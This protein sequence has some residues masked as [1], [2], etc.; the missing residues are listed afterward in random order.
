MEKRILIVDDDA[1]ILDVLNEALCGDG[2]SVKMAEGG[3]DVFKLIDEYQPDLVIIDYILNGINGGE[4]CH[5]IKTN[6]KTSYLPVIILSAHP[7]V[8][9]SLGYYNC[10][11]FIAKP[12]DLDYLLSKVHGLVEHASTK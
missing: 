10:D 7:R 5:Q 8:I 2:F 11:E 9:S 4:I 3:D 12:F 6:R 1:A